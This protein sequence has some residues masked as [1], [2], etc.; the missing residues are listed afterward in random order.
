MSAIDEL[1]PLQRAWALAYVGPAAGNATEACRHAKYKGTENALAVQGH[2][3]LHH[4]KVK[5]ALDE[6]MPAVRAKAAEARAEAIADAAEVQEYLTNVMR[7]NALE[8]QGFS[9]DGETLTGPPKIRDRLDAAKTLAKV[10]GL[11]I[12]KREHSGHLQLSQLP[13]DDL[14]KMLRETEDK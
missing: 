3:N 11:L 6:L 13:A 5:A 1:T 7:G 14:I 10:H 2:A 12:E 8:P 9:E 4:P